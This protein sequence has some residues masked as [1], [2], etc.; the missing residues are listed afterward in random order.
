MFHSTKRHLTAENLPLGRDTDGWPLCRFCQSRV[1]TRRNTICSTACRQTIRFLCFVGTQVQHVKRR[2]KGI[3]A[4][5]GCDTAKVKRI[6]ASLRRCG[7]RVLGDIQRNMGFDRGVP[8]ATWHMDH[9]VPVSQGGGV[10]PGMTIEEGLANLRTL[11]VPC[12]K[13]ETRALASRTTPAPP[14]GEE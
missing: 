12:H 14:G 5:C 4:L 11:C 7:W 1:P 8:S 2:D 6:F 9:I 10:A 13:G 3:C